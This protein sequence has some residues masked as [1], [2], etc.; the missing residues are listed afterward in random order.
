MNILKR[1][2]WPVLAGFIVAS[3]IM[4]IFEWINH[5]IFPL[6]VGLDVNDTVAV[7]AFTASLPWTAYILV[8]LGWAVGAFE[9][10]CTTAWLSNENQFGATTVLAAF[11][12]LAGIADVMMIGF[13]MVVA[14]L[15]LCIL[16]VCPYL[17]R[18]AL[19]TFEKKKRAKMAA[20]E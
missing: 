14:V 16:G 4:L 8:F 19:N 13:P 3:I 9:G 7:Q 15:G 1:W 5:F 11:L 18:L 20:N 17:G 2:V 6:P 10:G 12:V